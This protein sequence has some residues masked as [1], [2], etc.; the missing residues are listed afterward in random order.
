[1]PPAKIATLPPFVFWMPKNCCVGCELSPRS[2]VEISNAFDVHA[3]LIEMFT[4]P[5]Q[6]PSCRTWATRF[7]PASTTAMFIG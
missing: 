1:M 5:I 4:L 2:L 6:A 3:L 7:P